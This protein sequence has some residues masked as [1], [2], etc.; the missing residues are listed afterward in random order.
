MS[1]AKKPGAGRPG[2]Q[3]KELGGAQRGREQKQKQERELERAREQKQKQ[4]REQERA[5]L[6]GATISDVSFRL[7]EGEFAALMGENGAGKSTLCR[8]CN[9]LLLPDSGKVTACGRDTRAAR[10]SDIA[11]DVGFLF[12][13]PDRQLCQNTVR[14]EV[15]F[16]LELTMPGAAEPE[17]R[18]RCDETIELFSLDGARDPFGLSRGERQLVALASVLA[19]RPRLLVLDEPTTG[20]DY[21]ECMN[22]M[23]A[24]KRLQQAGTAILMITHDME[25]ALDFAERALILSRGRLIRDGRMKDVMKDAAS[26]G[27]ASLLPAQI[28]ALA[29]ALGEEFEDVCTVGEMA[30]RTERL[31]GRLSREQ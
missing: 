24:A 14:A 27:A 29:L 7:G 2:G 5:R 21:R 28:P 23:A 26:L 22:I 9:G 8:L 20:L 30:D 3:A 10:T 18:R 15:M 31:S 11:A 13:N 12:Q 4:E 19:R 17:R 16:G 1:Q 25:V 6:L